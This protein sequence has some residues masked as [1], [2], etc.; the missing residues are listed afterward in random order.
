MPRD[1]NLAPLDSTRERDPWLIEDLTDVVEC[2]Q[3]G[4]NLVLFAR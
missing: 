3:S 4:D 2:Q 1:L